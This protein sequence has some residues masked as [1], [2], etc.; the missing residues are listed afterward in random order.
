MKS[1]VKKQKKVKAWAII[2]G[3]SIVLDYPQGRTI[4][5]LSIYKTRSVA[6]SNTLMHKIVPVTITYSLPTKRKK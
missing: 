5:A 1:P 6:R 4:S 2:V 3:D